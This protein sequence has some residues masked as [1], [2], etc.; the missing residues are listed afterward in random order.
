MFGSDTIRY[1]LAM[2]NGNGLRFVIEDEVTRSRLIA[3]F[4]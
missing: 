2:I 1:G 3:N 4:E